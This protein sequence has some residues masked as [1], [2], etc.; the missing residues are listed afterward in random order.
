MAIVELTPGDLFAN[1]RIVRKLSEGGMG[2]IYVVTQEAT[3]R[4]R[5]LKLMHP[6]TVENPALRA[7]FIQEARIGAR[8]QSEHI[9]D[10]VDAGVDAETGVPWLAMELLEGED[11]GALL[12]RRGRLDPREVAAIFEQLCHAVGAAHAAGIV[13]RD[14]KPDNIFLAATK[15][16]GDGFT[17]KV[18]D[19]GIAKLVE[20]A[21]TSA[22]TGALGTPFWMAPEQT[23]R[24]ANISTST[25]V[26]GR[27]GRSEVSAAREGRVGYV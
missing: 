7:K 19:F 4:T 26:E 8:V 20:E 23:D 18:L 21:R 3:G 2:A 10:V 11:L 14:L 5:A 6:Q 24:R 27:S 12:A 1:F 9:I 25:D 22:N 13:H 15:R 16:T 17:L